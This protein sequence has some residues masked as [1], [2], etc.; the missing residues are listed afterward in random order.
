MKSHPRERFVIFGRV[1]DVVDGVVRP[2]ARRRCQIV[3]VIS[4]PSWPA[5]GDT[6]PF[7]HVHDAEVFLREFRVYDGNQGWNQELV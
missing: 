6:F 5:G 2:G 3:Q 4:P 7:I 1:L